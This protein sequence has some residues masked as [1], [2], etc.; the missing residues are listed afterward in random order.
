MDGPSLLFPLALFMIK[1]PSI[2]L[3]VQLDV[4]VLGHC[5]EQTC[6]GRRRRQLFPGLVWE[7][8]WGGTPAGTAIIQYS[9]G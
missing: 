6:T 5:E 9:E 8:Y 4:F 3:L 2:A 1:L 7:G